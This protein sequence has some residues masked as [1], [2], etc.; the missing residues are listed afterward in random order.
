MKKAM[1]MLIMIMMGFI[2]F[3]AGTEN[4]IS[5]LG[6]SAGLTG[7]GETGYIYGGSVSSIKVNP[8]L[9]SGLKGAG[10]MWTHTELNY[11][12]WNDYISVGMPIDIKGIKM[13]LGFSWNRLWID[14]IPITDIG[15]TIEGTD[16]VEIIN[17]GNTN[18]TM[19]EYGL[20]L[21]YKISK[22][23]IGVLG[24][25]TQGGIMDYTVKG[26]G[27]DVGITF[28]KDIID[29][30]EIIMDGLIN[31]MGIA[32]LIKDIGGTRYKWNTGYSERTDMIGELGLGLSFDIPIFGEESFNIEG[33]VSRYI[34]RS[35]EMNYKIGAELYVLPIIP[36]R[37]GYNNGGN[38]T[39]GIGIETDY[40]RVDYSYSGMRDIEPVHKVSIGLNW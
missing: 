36:V 1:I 24:K 15:D 26:I 25:Y 28:I 4:V 22:F 16:Y 12:Q 38:I 19:N 32:V 13:G 40:I 7:K 10:I 18:M 23:Q 21:S 31:N 3:G 6:Y 27:F 9:L 11:N 14:G 29:R 2:V 39:G 37:I 20:G 35:S 33:G 17:M 5:E 8:S 34:G 30:D